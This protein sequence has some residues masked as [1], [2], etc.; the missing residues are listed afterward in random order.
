MAKSDQL[1]AEELKKQLGLALEG[2]LGQTWE[3]DLLPAEQAN[4]GE[5]QKLEKPLIWAQALTSSTD[6]QMRILVPEKAWHYIGKNGLLAAGIDDATEADIR[7]TYLEIQGQALSGVARLIGSM[8]GR[9]V[10]LGQGQAEGGLPKD[11]RLVGL[12]LKDPDGES[13]KLYVRF[14]NQL[15]ARLDTDVAA[16][17]K[18]QSAQSA[19]AAPKPTPQPQQAAA[20]AAASSSVPAHHSHSMPG[21]VDLLLDVEMPVSVSFGRSYVPLKDVIK[22]TTGS[23]VELNRT[24]GDPVEVVVNNCVIARGE[25]V[26]VEGNYGVRIQQI[27]SRSERIRTLE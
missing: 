16:D 19:P 15:L 5:L 22:L 27:I 13:F 7:G 26:V 12:S 11:G 20:A 1:L 25:V 10:G 14:V 2:M 4:D 6:P 21:N 17:E 23:I 24:L 9:E 18:S 8:Q 3:I